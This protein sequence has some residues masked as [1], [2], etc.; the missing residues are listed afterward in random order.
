[1][2]K[3][4]VIN[5]PNLNLLG[6]RE[7]NVYGTQTLE[8]INNEI[9]AKADELGVEVIFYQSN[10]E[11]EIINVIHNAL[12]DYDAAVINPGAYTHYS[13]AIFDAIK[14][15]KKPFVEVHMS[16]INAR[17][18][19]RSKSVTAPA[20]VGQICGLGSKSYILGLQAAVF[21]LNSD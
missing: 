15:V 11:G 14:A 13:Y 8:T 10:C 2:K 1:M 7:P 19:F 3:I 9:K 4:M 16:N 6:M 17:D 21:A 5:G 12:T 20:C 18:E